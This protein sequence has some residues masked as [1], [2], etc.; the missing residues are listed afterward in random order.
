MRL[1]HP[2]KTLWLLPILL[3]AVSVWCMNCRD[4][5]DR[6]KNLP[7]PDQ[8]WNDAQRRVGDPSLNPGSRIVPLDV[9]TIG[10]GAIEI[11]IDPVTGHLVSVRDLRKSISL[12]DASANLLGLAP[13]SIQLLEP[14]GAGGYRPVDYGPREGLSLSANPNIRKLTKARYP[15]GTSVTIDWKDARGW[16]FTATIDLPAT[17]GWA[18]FRFAAR[19]PGAMVFSV[20]YPQFAGLAT[21]SSGGEADRF[22][23]PIESGVEIRNPLAALQRMRQAGDFFLGDLQY[24][25]GHEAMLPL[26]AYYSQA[27]GGGFA[28]YARDELWTERFFRFLHSRPATPNGVPTLAVTSMNW[29]ID[30]PRGN[31]PGELALDRPIRLETMEYGDWAAAAEIYRRWAETQVVAQNPVTRRPEP[32]RRVFEKMGVGVFGL[33]ASVDQSEWMRVFHELFT[34]FV[35]GDG[36]L[37]TMGWDFRPNGADFGGHDY[38]FYQAGWNEKYWVP[39]RPGFTRDMREVRARGDLVYP[40]LFD[41]FLHTGFPGWTGWRDAASASKDRG[42]PWIEQASVGYTGKIEALTFDLPDVDGDV[43]AICPATAKTRDF[44]EWRRKLLAHEGNPSAAR[45]VDGLYYD[46]PVTLLATH[47]FDRLGG[48]AHDHAQMGWGRFLTQAKRQM[49][50]RAARTD[51]DFGFGIENVTEP[52]VDFV[53]YYHLG[54]PGDGPY[55]NSDGNSPADAPRFARVNRL[56]MEGWARQIPMMEYVTHAF[57]PVRVGGKVQISDVIGD[58]WYWVAAYNYV[59]GG[60]LELIYYNEHPELFATI[61]PEAVT[62][63][64]GYPCAFQNGWIDR[65][66]MRGWTK[67]DLKEADP[68]KVEFLRRCVEL[69]LALG[70]PWLTSGRMLPPP[71]M[72]SLPAPVSFS[73]DFYS[74][75]NGPSREH[76]GQWVTHPVVVSAFAAPDDARRVAFFAANAHDQPIATSLVFKGE[77]YGLA[78]PIAVR[79]TRPG[80]EPGAVVAVSPGPMGYYRIPLELAPRDLV[81]IEVKIGDRH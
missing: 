28:L 62:C 70:N 30:G 63:P 16:T 33:S 47:C 81:R 23:A 71:G 32:R 75:I 79:A 39:F 80:E 40:F 44:V 66:G 35:P 77:R 34:G 2:K 45:V 5:D 9:V 59:N 19:V 12:L 72:D 31:A 26:V 13:F 10:N 21:L 78:G 14:D 18:E 37:F 55:R 6:A 1:S 64:G 51:P 76:R 22:A 43:H 57:G 46:I 50:E 74:S 56:V 24:P 41:I 17:E 20:T 42:A 7:T 48:H 38:A 8:I 54:A 52:F 67:D 11:S 3:V 69:R 15:G 53:D 65:D 25:S 4:E 68:D 49:F 60:M 36:V 61:H 58:A 27:A 73:Y 29:A